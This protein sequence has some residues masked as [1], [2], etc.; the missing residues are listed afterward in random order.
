MYKDDVDAQE[1]VVEIVLGKRTALGKL[2]VYLFKI[3]W[4]LN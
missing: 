1:A 2:P 3:H 4:Q